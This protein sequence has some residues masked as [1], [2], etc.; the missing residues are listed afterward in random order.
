MALL[1]PPILF[2]SAPAFTGNSF[3]IFFELSPFNSINDINTNA[4]QVTIVKQS[5]N[6]SIIKATAGIK[7][8]PLQID[9]YGKYFISINQTDLRNTFEQ[10]QFYKIQMR[11]TSKDLVYKQQNVESQSDIGASWF[12]KNRQYFSQ[13]SKICLIKNISTPT[14]F[15]NGFNENVQKTTF[16]ASMLSISGHLD[17][18]QNEKEYL[19]SYQ[20]KIYQTEDSNNIVLN[21]DEIYTNINDPNNFYYEIEEELLNSI[22]YTMQFTYI[23]NN[24]YVETK[25]YNFI[26]IEYGFDAID[27]TLTAFSDEENGRIMVKVTPT[28]DE[29]FIGNITIRRTS[30]KSDFHKWEDIKNYAFLEKRPL[31]FSFYDSTIESGVWYKYG[32]QKRNSFGDRGVLI[33]LLEPVMCIF[34]HIFIS[35][36]NRQLKI[37]FNPS[38][39]QFK[40]N[41]NETQQNTIGSKYP[42]VKR[43]GAN[44]FRSFPIGGLI[45]FLSDTTDWYDPHFM[46]GNF[47]LNQNELKLF[48]SKEEVYSETINLYQ[49]Y[50]QD[51][52]I[53][54]YNDYIYQK[55]FREKVYEFLYQHNVKLFRSTTEGNILIKLMN[56]D[57]QPIETLGRRLYSF[58][59]LAIEIDEANIKNYDKY[60]IQKIGDY[61]SQIIFNQEIFGQISKTFKSGENILNQ[62]NNKHKNYAAQGFQNKIPSLKRVKIEIESDPYVIIEQNGKLLKKEDN[63]KNNFENLFYGHIVNINGNEIIIYPRIQRR[64]TFTPIANSLDNINENSFTKN[65][66]IIY[67]SIFEL[68]NVSI[69]LLNFKY[70]TTAT[71]T[72]IANSKEIES[73][74]NTMKNYYYYKKIGQLYGTFSLNQNLIKKVYN[75]YFQKYSDYYQ[76]LLQVKSIQIEAP[77]GSV[78]YIKDSKDISYNKHI[79]EN[80]FLRLKDES[81]SILGLYFEGIQL[82]QTKN[83][84]YLRKDEYYI[85]PINYNDIQ[86]IKN[87]IQNYVYTIN[88][89]N[90]IYIQGIQQQNTLIIDPDFIEYIQNSNNNSYYRLLLNSASDDDLIQTFI[91]YNNH[92]YPFNKDNGVVYYPIQGIINYRCDIIKGE[93]R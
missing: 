15:I 82:K 39:N 38:L 81:T 46:N 20:I 93:Y 2:D 40:Y 35:D 91:Y 4:I 27:A 22:D 37:K 51:H 60:N 17:F 31:N 1:Y 23:T 56:I 55:E 79:I 58:T 25:T 28:T 34:Q 92:W 85:D 66:D 78:C 16:N 71:I 89:T 26:I 12:Y 41:V 68:N 14:L 10:N 6:T 54:E 70:D 63:N 77:P 86:N 57:F 61:Q 8:A 19:R 65:T 59:A 80:G 9:N 90:K 72:Y 67:L 18:N 11:F 3:K 52:Q 45:S 62:I 83:K 24:G 21:T 73:N 48:T 7:M 43:N 13:W 53:N 36:K 50:N 69:N 30:S 29:N 47:D 74:K 75:K 64:T 49:N 33:Q 32:I 84:K 44:Y 87:P 76:Q 88:P 5:T 42:Y